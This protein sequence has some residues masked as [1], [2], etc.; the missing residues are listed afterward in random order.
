MILEWEKLSNA[1]YV[2]GE[3]SVERRAGHWMTFVPNIESAIYISLRVGYGFNEA[4]FS[5]KAKK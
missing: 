4:D 5:D 2:S 3:Y 1:H